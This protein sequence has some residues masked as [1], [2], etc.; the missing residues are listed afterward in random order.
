VIVRVNRTSCVI[1][2]VCISVSFISCS[3]KGSNPDNGGGGEAFAVE[4]ES[5]STTFDVSGSEPIRKAPCLSASGGRAVAGMDRV[6]EWIQIPLEVP[7]AGTYSITIDYQAPEDSTI[8]V[9]LDAEVC[10]SSQDADFTLDQG[11]GTG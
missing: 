1:L 11:G 4:A 9:R 6:G 7:E 2:A 5:Y 3:D 8:V 10:G